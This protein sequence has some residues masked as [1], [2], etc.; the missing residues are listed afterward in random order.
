[1]VYF[2]TQNPNLGRFWRALEWKKLVYLMAVGI[3]YGQLVY[4]MQI[5]NLCSGNLVH[6]PRFGILY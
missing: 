4:F 6:F 5:C 2:Q 3:Y 1:M